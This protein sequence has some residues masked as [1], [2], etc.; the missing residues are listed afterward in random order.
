LAAGDSGLEGLA[1]TFMVRDRVH[2]QSEDWCKETRIVVDTGNS[3]LDAPILKQANGNELDL[4]TLGDEALDL[5]V[6][7][8]SA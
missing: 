5:Q 6:W 4:D 2:N 8:A 1:V 7:A 3:R